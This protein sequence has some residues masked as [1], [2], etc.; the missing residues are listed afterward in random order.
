MGTCPL[1]TLRMAGHGGTVS[2]ML[3]QQ[4][5]NRPNYTA[6]DESATQKRLIVLVEPKKWRGTT[7]NFRAS[8]GTCHLPLFYI[9]SGATVRRCTKLLRCVRLRS[10]L[11]G[12][13]CGVKLYSLTVLD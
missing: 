5:K 2:R 10:D 8:R 6:H 11:Y 13:G 7:K 3:E 9:R 12:V 4:T 1:P